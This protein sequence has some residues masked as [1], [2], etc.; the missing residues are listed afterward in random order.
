MIYVYL[1]DGFEETEMTAPLD[2]IRR[3]G[4]EAKTISVT[5]KKEVTGSHGITV[6]ADLLESDPGY[7]I[8]RAE[9]VLLPGG[10][11]GTIGLENSECVRRAVTYAAENGLYIA[12]ICAAPSILGKMG[13]LKGLKAVC[14]PGF[15]KY[16]EG[17]V[18][19][20]E[21]TVCVTDGKFITAAGMG[22]AVEFGLTIVMALCGKETA[23]KIRDGIIA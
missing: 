3:A 7:D 15:E 8:N 5:G 12:A 9:L 21:G 23:E 20:C 10:M 22:A 1:A 16:L 6:I 4:L 11:P 18:A 19:P 2:I 17:A 14:Y 13:L